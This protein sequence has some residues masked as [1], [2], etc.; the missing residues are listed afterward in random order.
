MSE[1]NI[2]STVATPGVARIRRTARASSGRLPIEVTF[3]S[4]P[5]SRHE[6]WVVW[7]IAAARPRTASRLPTASATISAV[8][9][10]RRLR[11]PR[12]RR[13]I[14]AVRGRKRTRRSR[15]SPASWP[16]TA[17]PVASSASRRSTRTPRWI[18]G[19]AASGGASRPTATLR[20]STFGIDPEAD[21]DREEGRAEVA[22]EQ[23]R[24]HDAERDAD[25]G[26]E[27]AE[28]ERGLRRRR[29]RSAGAGRRSPSSRRSQPS[30]ARPASSSCSRSA[31]APR[32]AR[33]R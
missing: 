6:A 7:E 12:L 10:L 14:W 22:H 30:A 24:E 33:A 15:R 25:D 8:A 4:S 11:R 9:R 21:V 2:G 20:S 19:H 3:T 23:V 1:A 5:W 27:R 17:E 26:A 18:A 13:P 28:Q 29:A 32:A 16:P 31:R